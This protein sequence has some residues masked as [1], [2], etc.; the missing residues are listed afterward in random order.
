MQTIGVL[1]QNLFIP[2]FVLA[3]IVS[4]WRGTPAP[5]WLRKS[6]DALI[7][8]FLLVLI[9]GVAIAYNTGPLETKIGERGFRF[10]WSAPEPLPTILQLIVILLFVAAVCGA[11]FVIVAEYKRYSAAMASGAQIAAAARARMWA[12][13]GAILIA[14]VAAFVAERFGGPLRWTTEGGH[15]SVWPFV[16]QLTGSLIFV[17]AIIWLWKAARA[18]LAKP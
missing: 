4:M 7:V 14:V 9:A 3:V 2:A 16:V 15:E 13:V 6:I 18:I 10:V 12:I 8:L 5:R 17:A 11:W 1:A